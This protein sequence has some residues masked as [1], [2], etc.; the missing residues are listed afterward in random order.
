MSNQYSASIYNYLFNSI[1]AVVMIVNG[2]IMVPI[3]FYY[4]PVATYGAW[5]ASGNLVAMIGLLEAGFAGV[6][7]QK[8]AAAISKNNRQEFLTLAGSNI[9][10]AFIISS[11]ILVLGSTMIPFIAEVVNADDE[12]S[13][14]ITVAYIIS[15]L[16]S[17]IAVLVSLFGAFPQVWQETKQIGIINMFVNFLAILIMILCL[18]WGFGVV[19]LAIGYIS[20]SFVNLILQSLWILRYWKIK[21]VNNP[22]FSVKHSFGIVKECIYPFFARV[23]N[24]VMGQSQSL[25]LAA[26]MAPSV[27]AVYDI[28]SKVLVC[29][30]GFVSMANGSFF[31]LLSLV[32]SKNKT[33]ELNQV[34]SN[35][36]QYFSVLVVAV[37]IFGC[38]FSKM[39]IDLWVGLDKFGGD[40]LLFAIGVSLLVNQYKS[41]FNNLL[42]T[43]GNIKHSSIIDICSLLVY[44]GLLLASLKIFEVYSIP[45]S[46]LITNLVFGFWYVKILLNN[47]EIKKNTIMV[48]ICKNLLISVPLICLYWILNINPNQYLYQIALA[49]GFIILFLL[50]VFL[51]N[52]SISS[53]INQKMLNK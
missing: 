4:M 41:F 22:I 28:T 45:V 50:Y 32:F 11:L 25:I 52:P 8:M 2:I 51:V 26:S 15:L 6:I 10:T 18:V 12:W 44:I 42:F 23:S 36:L 47:T 27:A 33:F 46:L 1:N 7:T 13:H 5:L 3:Y 34:V 38:C 17:A 21:E 14:D 49:L 24:V 35:I 20:R 43:S 30:Y 9:I 39:I 31:A 53:Y 16:S 19:S 40:Y 48:P 29:A 37:L